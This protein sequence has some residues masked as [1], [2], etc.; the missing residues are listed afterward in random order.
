LL[1]HLEEQLAA[2]TLYLNQGDAAA[3]LDLLPRQAELIHAVTSLL[4]SLPREHRATTELTERLRV[5]ASTREE[6]LRRVAEFIA[7]RRAEISS[8]SQAAVRLRLFRR[9]AASAEGEVISPVWSW[10]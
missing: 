2:E 10:A 9:A 7:S 1:A 5:I 4:K 8:L 3:L 6:T